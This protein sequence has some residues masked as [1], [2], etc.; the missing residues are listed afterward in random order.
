[1]K[2]T[3]LFFFTF[4]NVL[5]S[6]NITAN[7]KIYWIGLNTTQRLH[8]YLWFSVNIQW[9]GGDWFM[10][11]QFSLLHKVYGKFLWLPLSALRSRFWSPEVTFRLVSAPELTGTR[12]AGTSTPE[13]TYNHVQIQFFRSCRSSKIWSA[14]FWRNRWQE[15]LIDPHFEDRIINPCLVILRAI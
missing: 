4:F 5:Y 8:F 3:K 14:N 9:K 15:V 6:F 11:A 10:W 2:Q 7:T 1:M 12:A 13:L